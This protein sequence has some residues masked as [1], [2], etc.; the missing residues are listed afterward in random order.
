[1][2][3]LNIDKKELNPKFLI[4]WKKKYDEQESSIAKIEKFYE[5][6][7]RSSLLTN[8]LES[9]SKFKGSRNKYSSTSSLD[10]EVKEDSELVSPGVTR[11]IKSKFFSTQINQPIKQPSQALN[12]PNSNPGVRSNIFVE[13]DDCKSPVKATRKQQIKSFNL[14]QDL[15]DRAHNPKVFHKANYLSPIASTEEDKDT[16]FDQRNQ[17]QRKETGISA[18]KR[19]QGNKAMELYNLV[20]PSK[21]TQKLTQHKSSKSFIL[22]KN[23]SS[24]S[25]GFLPTQSIK[26]PSKLATRRPSNL[27]F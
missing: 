26:I 21:S 20:K 27:Y 25:F 11:E 10:T 2:Y 17:N 12:I 18:Q 3:Q 6:P 24:T 22:K 23:K 8:E 4:G 19:L 14:F 9:Q 1:M 16:I 7:Q 5:K 15:P 13:D